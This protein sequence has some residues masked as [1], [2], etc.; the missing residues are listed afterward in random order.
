MQI[1]AVFRV[2]DDIFMMHECVNGDMGKMSPYDNAI[3]LQCLNDD[4]TR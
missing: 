1:I 2:D 3:H 4:R